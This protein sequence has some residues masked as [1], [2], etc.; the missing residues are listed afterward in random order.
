VF[1][2]LTVT[3][4]LQVLFAAHY[5]SITFNKDLVLI[6]RNMQNRK[7][8]VMYFTQYV[9]IDKFY[10]ISCDKEDMRFK[11]YV[12]LKIKIALTLNVMLC[13]LAGG[14]QHFRKNCCFHLQGS[15]RLSQQL[16]TTHWYPSAKL[17]G[18]TF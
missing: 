10:S 1:Q 6:Y 11:V 15:E 13:C 3:L 2:Q 7:T 9:A 12:E 5:D 4:H 16:P 18:V 8:A 17:H 14:Y